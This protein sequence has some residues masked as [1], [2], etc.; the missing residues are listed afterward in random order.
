LLPAYAVLF[1]PSVFV[2]C[3][4][5]AKD[6]ELHTAQQLIDSPLIL[7]GAH[8]YLHAL[9]PVCVLCLSTA[10]KDAEVQAAQQLIDEYFKVVQKRQEDVAKADTA[11]GT[12]A[13]AAAAA[14]EDNSSEEEGWDGEE[15]GGQQQRPK[16]R[17]AT[18]QE[19]VSHLAA[20][21]STVSLPF[22]FFGLC[23]YSRRCRIAK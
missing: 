14:G 10:A 20:V 13:V 19:E 6:A 15:E 18:F 2:V 7:W 3:C 9:P 17:K 12:A 1:L 8:T 5:D 16:R 23:C 21:L 22:P 4:A 11:G